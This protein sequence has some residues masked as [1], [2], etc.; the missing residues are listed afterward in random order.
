MPKKNYSSGNTDTKSDFY[1]EFIPSISGGIKVSI[2]SKTKSIHGSTLNR[3][4]KQTL[5]DLGVKHGK[6]SLID[7]AGQYFV[8]RARIEATVKSANPKLGLE[9][10][11]VF[12]K[13]AR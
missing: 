6:L 10:L 8:L 2:E 7:N 13:H 4:T 9:S 5:S 3:I 1:V 12:K 11:C